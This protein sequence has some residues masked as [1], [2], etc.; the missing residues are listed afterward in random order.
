MHEGRDDLH[1][2]E[3]AG[4]ATGVHTRR[5]DCHRVHTRRGGCHGPW[6][7][8]VVGVSLGRWKTVPVFR[9]IQKLRRKHLGQG[10][11]WAACTQGGAWLG[12][13]LDGAIQ[14]PL[15]ERHACGGEANCREGRH[16][17]RREGYHA[18]SR[19]AM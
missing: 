4:M 6:G 8:H 3:H 9:R 2:E 7:L 11:T 13:V 15:Y 17:I 19:D 16:T 12:R 5:C 14:G 18:E 1:G 10:A